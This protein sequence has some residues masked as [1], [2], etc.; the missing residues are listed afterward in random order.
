TLDAGGAAQ[1]TVL[2]PSDPYLLATTVSFQAVAGSPIDAASNVVRLTAAVAGTFEPTLDAPDLPIVEGAVAP[3]DDGTF[4]FVGGSG[5]VAQ[6]YD[7]DLEEWTTAGATFAVGTLGR[8]TTL[9]DGRIL[10]TGGIDPTGQPTAAAAVWDPATG[11]ST[12]LAMGSPRAGH[13]A[14]LLPDGR[15]LITGGFQTV[16]LTDLLTFFSGIQGTTELFDPSTGTF[17]A[18]PGLFEPRALHSSTT[19]T[20]GKVLIAGGLTLVPILNVPTVSNTAYLFSNGSFGLPSFFDAPRMLHAA[21]ALPGG[22]VL[23]V[24]GLSLDL[25]AVI[26]SG[27]LTQLVVGTLD[28]G[29]VFTAGFLGGTFSAV[30]GLGAGRAGAGVVALPGGDVLIAGGIDVALSAGGVQIDLPTSADRYDGSATFQPT[31]ALGAGR[32]LPVLTPLP[33]GTVLVAGGGAASAEVY[34]P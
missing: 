22:K 27:D 4:L 34:Q 2:L 30:T 29:Q 21:C 5:P 19:T 11:Q 12:S 1:A 23:L 15:V 33:D 16:D 6:E 8:S 25:T 7:P 17:A 14:S 31:G 3:T 32:F 26:Q 13:G 10:F 20:A 24:G 9:A 18:G 28:D